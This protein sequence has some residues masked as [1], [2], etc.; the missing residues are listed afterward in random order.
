ME[1]AAVASR[2]K[3]GRICYMGTEEMT[4]VFE[5]ELQGIVTLHHGL[6]LG[7]VLG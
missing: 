7:W 5:A 6:G 2:L 4:T 1:A 3:E